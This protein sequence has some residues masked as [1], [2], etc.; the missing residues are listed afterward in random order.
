MELIPAD[1]HCIIADGTIVCCDRIFNEWFS[2]RGIG[3][4]ARLSQLF[5]TAREY[6]PG[7]IY[8][9]ADKLGKKRS[10]ALIKRT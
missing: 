9:D 2:H 1:S 6:K 4:G 7:T 3:P 8:E 5:P 10:S